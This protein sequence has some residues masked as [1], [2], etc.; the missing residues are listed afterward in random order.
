MLNI[1]INTMQRSRSLDSLNTI[2][3]AVE[4]RPQIHPA[5]LVVDSILHQQP[6]TSTATPRAYLPLHQ[7]AQANHQ[8]TVQQMTAQPNLAASKEMYFAQWQAWAQAPNAIEGEQR[9]VALE[10]MKTWLSTEISNKERGIAPPEYR[11]AQPTYN[12]EFN[13]LDQNRFYGDSKTYVARGTCLRLSG[14]GLSNLPTFP[15]DLCNL[16]VSNN[17]LTNLHDYCLPSN[18]KTLIAINNQIT[19]LPPL[20]SRLG[21]LDVQKNQLRALPD[22]PNGLVVLDAS[23]NDLQALPHV[24][25]DALRVLDISSNRIRHLPED[26]SNALEFLDAARNNLQSIPEGLPNY[27]EYLDVSENELGRLPDKL[28]A[29]LITLN[30]A[31]NALTDIPDYFNQSFSNHPLNVEN[32]YICNNQITALP[33]SWS[34]H[35]MRL[36]ASN[37]QLTNIPTGIPD[38]IMELHLEDNHITSLPDEIYTLS[39]NSFDRNAAEVYL[40]G[41]DLS[42]ATREELRTRANDSGPRIYFSMAAGSADAA[43]AELLSIAVARWYSA[44][45]N[46]ST[47]NTHI[48]DIQNTWAQWQHAPHA[49]A[50]ATFLGRLHEVKETA[51]NGREILVQQVGAWLNKVAD[52]PDLRAHVFQR[53]EDAIGFCEDRAALTFLKMQ[54]ESTELGVRQGKYDND[55]SKVEEIARQSFRLEELEKIA[56]DKVRSLLS[57]V[58]EIEVHLAYPI[59]LRTALQLD[60]DIIDGRFL[61]VSRVTPEDIAAAEITVKKREEEYFDRYLASEWEPWQSVLARQCPKEYTL[62]QEKKSHLCDGEEFTKR[63]SDY[64][65]QHQLDN[66]ERNR[67]DYANAVMDDIAYTVNGPLTEAFRKRALSL[68]EENLEVIEEQQPLKRHAATESCASPFTEQKKRRREDPDGDTSGAG[69]SGIA[70]TSRLRSSQSTSASQSHEGMRQQHQEQQGSGGTQHRHMASTSS[71]KPRTAQVLLP[72]AATQAYT[73]DNLM[74][75][76]ALTTS[77]GASY[78]GQYLP[79]NVA[80]HAHPAMYQRPNMAISQAHDVHVNHPPELSNRPPI[81]RE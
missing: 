78:A 66:N 48:A 63:L 56:I 50:F 29:R 70:G 15:N 37:N 76:N 69:S 41:N 53:A 52:N 17:R 13:Y 4:N 75:Q 24:L 7:I 61:S 80:L 43:P 10:R 49:N 6:S 25:P 32:L 35:L 26:F 67:L 20:P 36:D 73:H 39:G 47:H 40:E 42:V 3:T 74:R 31:G 68:A 19:H 60:I 38:S 2:S 11:P 54:R 64:L 33:E 27:I 12:S 58:D 65:A 51:K 34:P 30:V 81:S 9:A 79:R 59:M 71:I 72:R 23:E 62:A 21:F 8:M 5:N 44:D 14:L 57:Y 77:D 16:D 45:E 46:T 18:L 22:L 55:I 28:P 1:R